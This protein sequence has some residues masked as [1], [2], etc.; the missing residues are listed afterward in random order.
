VVDLKKGEVTKVLSFKSLTLALLVVATW[1]G[2][3]HVLA[4]N[5]RIT[6]WKTRCYLILH[7]YGF[8]HARLIHIWPS[9]G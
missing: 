7:G 5:F 6:R 8:P 9:Y 2:I 1:F 4:F 3:L